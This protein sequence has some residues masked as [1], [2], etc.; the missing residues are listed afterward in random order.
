MNGNIE[1]RIEVSNYG[2]RRDV[3]LTLPIPMK[4]AY[5]AVCS[6]FLSNSGGGTDTGTIKIVSRTIT[7]LTFYM[8][9]TGWVTNKGLQFVV[10]DV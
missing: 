7:T 10:K 3:E 4:D 5:Y 9:T 1:Q 6:S 2:D 8:S